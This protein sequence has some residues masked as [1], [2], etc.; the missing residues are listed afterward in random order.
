M[1][2]IVA[3]TMEGIKGQFTTGLT[4]IDNL[5]GGKLSG[6]K[7]WFADGLETARSTVDSVMSGISE[8]FNE[9]ITSAENSIRNG[10]EKIKGLF[11][12]SW[13]LPDLKTPHFSITGSFGLKSAKCSENNHKVVCRGWYYDFT[14][15]F[16]RK[17]KSTFG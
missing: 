8:K 6:I 5:T 2:G 1:Q 11:H 14:N 3:A 13:K 15:N 7:T 10:I 4:F 17:W 12:F 16:W 9:K